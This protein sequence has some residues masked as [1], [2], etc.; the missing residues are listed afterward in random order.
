MCAFRGDRPTEL[1]SRP[2]P[3]SGRDPRQ[4]LHRLDGVGTVAEWP[5]AGEEADGVELTKPR[6]ASGY[7]VRIDLGPDLPE[8]GV[9]L[10]PGA[11]DTIGR[12][13][14]DAAHD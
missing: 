12:S 1:A 11:G 9:K 6:R 3:Q 13:F 8:S 2:G 5:E 14:D 4:P 10:Q 7:V